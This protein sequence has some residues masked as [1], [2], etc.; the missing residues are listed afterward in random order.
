MTASA[1]V[2]GF[3]STFTWDGAAIAEL[4][5][6]G[7][8]K[9]SVKTADITSFDSDD[10]YEE[11][12]PTILSGGEFDIEGFLSVSDT[13]GQVAMLTDFHAKS[14]KTWIITFTS[15]TGTTW[16]GSG[17]LTAFETGDI[18]V[19]GV[20][21]FKATIK[22]TGKP[23][24]AIAA[25]TGGTF[26]VTGN[27]GAGVVNPASASGTYEYV[28]TLSQGATSYTLTPTIATSTI[29]L[30]DATGA[31]QTIITTNA[32]TSL[33]AP[34]NSIHTIYLMA[35][36]SGKAKLTYTIHVVEPVT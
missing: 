32:S 35:Q 14:K 34:T 29:T 21:T 31:T 4:T 19:D 15:S 5:K 18:N 22:N 12:I 2:I 1:S 20:L 9:L 7:G 8:V 26:I 13:L 27:N 10:G 28:V 3:G 23:A 30:L 36:E 17:Y 25:S 33:A 24:L 11:V 6:I 16:T